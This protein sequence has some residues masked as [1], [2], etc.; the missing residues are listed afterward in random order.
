VKI[1]AVVML[2]FAVG[3]SRQ[4]RFVPFVDNDTILALD[5]ETGKTCVSYKQTSTTQGG[6]P[7][8]YCADLYNSK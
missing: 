1:L 7:M 5:T 6:T 4:Q 3:C 8:P 2:L